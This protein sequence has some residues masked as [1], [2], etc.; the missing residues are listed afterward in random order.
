MLFFYPLKNIARVSFPESAGSAQQHPQHQA[1]K[2]RTNTTHPQAAFTA[3][4][5]PYVSFIIT[6]LDH[7]T[8]CIVA[9]FYHCLCTGQ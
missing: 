9:L 2:V 6:R 7:L 1:V 4:A 3:Y 5:V 8:V